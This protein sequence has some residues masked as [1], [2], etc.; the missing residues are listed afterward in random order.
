MKKDIIF[1]P[2]EGVKVAII[3]TID[4]LNEAQWNVIVINRNDQPITGVFV[5]SK[6]YGNTES[7]I[8]AAIKTSTLRHF[9]PE[10]RPA[11]YVVVEPIMPDVFPLNNEFWISYFLGNQ[12]YDKKFIFVPDSIVEDNII[13]IEPLG[14]EGV[15]HD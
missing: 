4:E 5:T 13:K 2:V 11:D 3:R 10:I 9:F 6:G 7:G 8:N 12:I 15:L 1:H 14:L